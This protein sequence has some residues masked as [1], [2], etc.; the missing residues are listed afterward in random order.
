MKCLLAW[1]MAL[2]QELA[3]LMGYRHFADMQTARRMMGS[4]A[5]ALAFVDELLAVFKPAFDA[6]AAEYLEKLSRV[7]GEKIDRIAPWNEPFYA[8]D[9]PAGEEDFDISQLTPYFSAEKVITGMMDIWEHL[10]GLRIEEQKALYISPGGTCPE[11]A[12]EV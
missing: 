12:V 10:L 11:G 6:E 9:I 5:A 7:K 4:G 2:R 3:E 1:A 8:K